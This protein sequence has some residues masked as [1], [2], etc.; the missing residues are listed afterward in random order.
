MDFKAARP[1]GGLSDINSR[2]YCIY[3]KVW[4]LFYHLRTDFE[5]WVWN[6]DKRLREG[7]QKWRCAESE[8][9]RKTVLETFGTRYS[10]LWRLS[11]F[12]PTKQIVVDPMHAWYLIILQ[13]FFR[14]ETALGLDNLDMRTTQPTSA[15]IEAV[16][17]A[18]ESSPIAFRHDFAFPPDLALVGSDP[19]APLPD[20]LS[21]NLKDHLKT[22]DWSHLAEGRKVLRSTRI[23]WMKPI[24]GDNTN[25]ANDVAAIHSILSEACPALPEHPDFEEKLARH[26]WSALLYVCNDLMVFPAD[27]YLSFA[28]SQFI[29][30]RAVTKAELAAAL[31]TWVRF[32]PCIEL[33]YTDSFQRGLMKLWR[34]HH[35]CGPTSHQRTLLLLKLPGLIPLMQYYYSTVSV[36]LSVVSFF[37]IL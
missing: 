28:A 1:F 15:V 33:P 30:E 12:Q 8:A 21:E 5:A 32:G 4:H 29:A 3:C 27:K 13:R 7:A 9:E 23:D 20:I 34:K 31:R 17:V 19:D 37:K 18:D 14:G 22:L 6:D 26:R 16:L 10:E 11:Y 35:L 25:G 2:L 36:I 24:L